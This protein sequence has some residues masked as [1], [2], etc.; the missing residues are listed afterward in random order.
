MDPLFE[1]GAS[2]EVGDKVRIVERYF[3]GGD[4]KYGFSDE[5][6][7]LRGNIYTISRVTEED[8]TLSYPV[9]DDNCKYNLLEFPAR[10]F[11]WSSGM[12]EAVYETDKSED[13]SNTIKLKKLNSVKLKFRL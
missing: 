5:M 8:S 6:A 10:F 2:F 11:D 4:Y 13:H 7:K 9:N 12:L 1:V 3:P